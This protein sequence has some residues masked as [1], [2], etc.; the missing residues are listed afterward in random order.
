M[1]RS[2]WGAM[3][4]QR[5]LA[6]LLLGIMKELEMITV[7]NGVPSNERREGEILVGSSLKDVFS[8]RMPLDWNF[9]LNAWLVA[10]LLVE[11]RLSFCHF[12]GVDMDSWSRKTRWS[13]TKGAR[14]HVRPHALSVVS[15]AQGLC[16]T[17]RIT[18]LL[19]VRTSVISLLC[20]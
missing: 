9:P 2:A 4:A 19:V 20:P 10:G 7:P 18:T 12:G 8:R 17:W 1:V 5:A 13:N 3:R 14:M 6:A 15:M 16:T 11:G